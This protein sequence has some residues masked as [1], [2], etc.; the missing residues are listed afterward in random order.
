MPFTV[1][2]EK[3]T[4]SLDLPMKFEWLASLRRKFHGKI[5]PLSLDTHFL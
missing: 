5:K 1:C 2:I 4:I 3:L